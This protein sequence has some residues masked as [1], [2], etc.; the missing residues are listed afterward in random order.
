ME[1]SSFYGWGAR[2]KTVSQQNPIVSIQSEENSD[3]LYEFDA[4]I[5]IDCSDLDTDTSKY[6]DTSSDE[7]N[8]TSQYE[9][10]A[11]DPTNFPSVLVKVDWGLVSVSE[12]QYVY[13]DEEKNSGRAMCW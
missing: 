8:E 1:P 10:E 2:K 5:G 3:N 6:G 4:T 7:N 11:D 9:I 13:T 12:G